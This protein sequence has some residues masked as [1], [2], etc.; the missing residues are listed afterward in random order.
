VVVQAA[1]AGA[2]AAHVTLPM[3]RRC[4]PSPQPP[5]LLLLLLL[6]GG[7]ARPL[8]HSSSWRQLW[9]PQWTPWW[10]SR[11]STQG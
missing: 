7:P 10:L 4:R 11:T 2:L 6:V 5:A 9:R 8:L 3:W 1:G